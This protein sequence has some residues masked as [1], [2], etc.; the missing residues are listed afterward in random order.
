M[1][2]LFYQK[3]R[4]FSAVAIAIL[5][6]GILLSSCGGGTPDWDTYTSAEGEFSVIMPT[7]TKLTEQVLPTPFGKQVVHF[8][9]WKPASMAIDKFRLFQ[10]S[11]TECPSGYMA[12]S[13]SLQRVMDSCIAMRVRDFADVEVSIENIRFNGY[14]GR[15]FI[16][17]VKDNST[18]AIV[19]QCIVNHRLYDLTVILKRNY[20]TNPEVHKFYNSFK[21]LYK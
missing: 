3:N 12:D 5:F 14:P 1:W 9:A 21:V 13:M 19:K 10:V 16:F 11:F 6:A 2:M 4:R 18:I 8:V 20:A 7:N 15:A 17:D